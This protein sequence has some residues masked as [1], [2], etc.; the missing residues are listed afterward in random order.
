MFF[1][2]SLTTPTAGVTH[3]TQRFWQASILSYPGV[4]AKP[5]AAEFL[6][7]CEFV[8]DIITVIDYV[9]RNKT[10]WKINANKDG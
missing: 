5:S 2:D 1:F 4:I 10:E 7:Y 8:I 3:N 6:R 9:Y